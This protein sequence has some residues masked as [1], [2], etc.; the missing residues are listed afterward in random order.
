MNLRLRNKFFFIQKIVAFIFL[1]GF[2][3]CNVNPASTESFF[4]TIDDLPMMKGLEELKDSAVMFSTLKGRIF[5]IAANGKL[6]EK[7]S[8]RKVILFYA[9]T[10][11]QLGWRST[12]LNTWFREGERLQLKISINKGILTT[13]FSLMPK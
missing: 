9:Q 3:I 2:F 5:E 1:L 11:P 7:I 8:K 10:L 12:G 13:H 6:G 4:S